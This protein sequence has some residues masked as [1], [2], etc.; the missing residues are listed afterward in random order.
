MYN[1]CLE[2]NKQKTSVAYTLEEFIEKINTNQ[3]Y[4]YT[5]WCGDE[6]CENKIKD[7]TGAHSRCLPFEKEKI[8]D[9]CV[10]CGKEAKHLVIW[11]RQY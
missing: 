3:G 1:N 2:R 8:A 5:M 7:E 9:K 4:I 6:E 10:C 11:G